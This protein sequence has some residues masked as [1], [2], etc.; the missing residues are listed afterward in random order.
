MYSPAWRNID[1]CFKRKFI[2]IFYKISLTLS[3]YFIHF[4]DNFL[5]RVAILV[6]PFD[7]F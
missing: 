6:K 3:T 1:F 7:L 2:D 4:R 5:S